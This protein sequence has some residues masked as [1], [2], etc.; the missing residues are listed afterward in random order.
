MGGR[1]GGNERAIEKDR[2]QY[3]DRDIDRRRDG[4]KGRKLSASQIHSISAVIAHEWTRMNYN[5]PLSRSRN[6]I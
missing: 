3:S 6:Q 4:D 5:Q 2:E 1:E